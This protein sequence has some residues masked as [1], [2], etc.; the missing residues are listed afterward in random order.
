MTSI[1][2]NR[3]FSISKYRKF[4]HVECSV[5]E[6][7]I[8]NYSCTLKPVS[9]FNNLLNAKWELKRPI[10]NFLVTYDSIFHFKLEFRIFVQLNVTVWHKSKTASNFRQIINI[11]KIDYCNV[12]ANLNSYPWMKDLLF[13]SE[14]TLPGLVRDCPYEGA[15]QAHLSNFDSD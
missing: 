5:S 11:N 9:R 15:R 13:W 10:S 14:V 12:K 1:Y 4:T 2:A 8:G 3:S 6:K 7:T